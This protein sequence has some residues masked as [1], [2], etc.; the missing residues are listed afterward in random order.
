[1]SR[2]LWKYR[3]QI[4]VEHLANSFQ[5]EA[6]S[7]GVNQNKVLGAFLKQVKKSLLIERRCHCY[8]IYRLKFECVLECAVAPEVIIIKRQIFQLNPSIKKG[9]SLPNKALGILLTPY[10]HLAHVLRIQL[11]VK[12]GMVAQT[13]RLS[14]C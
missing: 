14:Q 5:Q 9:L 12:L 4:T 7:V 13:R 10:K 3:R 8:F 1:M 6:L 2:S 11:V